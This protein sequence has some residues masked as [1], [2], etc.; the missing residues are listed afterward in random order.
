ME[1]SRFDDIFVTPRLKDRL[2]NIG[3]YP[4]TTVIAPMGYGKTTAIKWWSSRRT[5][6][7]QSS[8]FYKQLVIT[9][10]VTDFWNGF[11]K[12]FIEYPDLY[13]QLITLGYPK[14][15]RALSYCSEILSATLSKINSDIYFVFD[16][17]HVLPPGVATSMIMFFAKSLPSNIHIVLISRNQ[18]F[19]EKEKM[20]LGHQLY[21]ISVYDLRLNPD[22]LNDYA[23]ICKLE[24]SQEELD[25][26]AVSSEGWFSIV[27]LN[28]KSY[29]R[30]GKWLSST[31]DIYS[32][33]E[34]V[35]LEPLSE[36]EREFLILIGIT[37]E[38]TKEQAAYLWAESGFDGDSDELLN[39]LSKNNA[40]ISKTGGLYRYHH[41]LGKCVRHLFSQKPEEYQKNSYTRL[42]DWY[43]EHNY[44]IHAYYAY[45]EAENY[46]K[47][48]ACIEKDRS[49]SLNYEHAEDFFSWIGNCAEEILL[50]HPGALAVCMLTMFTF[51]NIEELYRLKSLLLKSLEINDTLSE[52]EKNNLL[53]DAE[54]SESFTAFN[55]IPAMSEYHR[56]ACALLTR[57]TYSVDSGDSWTFGSPSVFMMYHRA[58]G[59]A[60]KENEDMKEC[61][62]YYYRVT[63][64]HGNGSEL[65]F[66]AE[67]NYERGDFVS[68]DILNKT[69]MS[70]AKKNNQLSIILTIEFLNM[71]LELLRGN[72][73]NIENI[74]KNLREML[75]RENQY[76]LLNVVDIC[77]MF[78]S[79][80]LEHPENTSTWLSE[81]R[82]SDTL[83]TFPALPML[84][85]FYNQF[86]LAKGEYI[87]LIARKEECLNLYGIFNYVHCI[88]ILHIQ[89]AAANE[90]IGRADDAMEELRTALSMAMPDN[91]LMSFAGNIGYISKQLM[92]LKKDKEYTEYIDKILKLSD[93][94]QAGKE[95]IL[96]EYFEER[97][98]YGLSE[99]EVEIANLAAERMTSAE[100]ARELH[101]SEGTVRNHLSRVFDKMGISG[102]KKNKRLELEELLKGQKT[103][104]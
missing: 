40:F 74:L 60:D 101:I 69:A 67:L 79:S 95:K 36:E 28:F 68:A 97:I 80:V 94:V 83:V 90:K 11:C 81:G 86:L 25:E 93:I 75:R 66:A 45:A 50:R 42:G 34:E 19:N 10:S 12:M 64:G 103:N 44:Y 29:E 78:I 58:V 1:F 27:Y 49:S 48:L 54:I 57:D 2:S 8:L 35:L 22:E 76:D 84:N 77:Q 32:L 24:A 31:N 23:D 21:E 98:D 55:D 104:S 82:L 16:D 7:N 5:K 41:M 52:E 73:D 30:N 47:I 43:M 46:E 88:I 38:F 99:R 39:S 14:D 102:S 17:I 72:Y 92:K 51:N 85:T 100:I 53:G 9:D 71:R 26:L 15:A 20:Q 3:N 18:I 59:S 65:V 63:S 13:E 61:M 4:I 56:R 91:I 37:V 87:Q 33:I 89:L 96:N 70:A 6:S 62:P